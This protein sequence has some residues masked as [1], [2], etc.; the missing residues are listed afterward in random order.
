M[1]GGGDGKRKEVGGGERLNSF[2]FYLL[3]CGE[4]ERQRKRETKSMEA[5]SSARKSIHTHSSILGEIFP[6]NV[7]FIKPRVRFWR[8]LQ[9]IV[10]SLLEIFL[11]KL[12]LLPLLPP[13]LPHPKPTFALQKVS[14][15][16]D[17]FQ[18]CPFM[19]LK[20]MRPRTTDVCKRR[21]ERP[22]RTSSEPYTRS[23][24]VSELMA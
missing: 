3:S 20:P 21:I 18:N 17:V 1:G 2:Y 5:L 4:I 11:P 13:P 14:Y 8:G 19:S 22:F 23:L 15:A 10:A 12:V 9:T 16:G 6:L 24:K 7:V